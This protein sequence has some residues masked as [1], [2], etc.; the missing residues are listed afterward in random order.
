MTIPKTVLGHVYPAKVLKCYEHW[1]QERM[2]F[3]QFFLRVTSEEWEITD[4]PPIATTY[5]LF[6][7]NAS[8][9]YICIY[10]YILL[11]LPET[12]S[13]KRT[14]I[15]WKKP[16]PQRKTSFLHSPVSLLSWIISSMAWEILT[17]RS[18]FLLVRIIQGSW[19]ITNPNNALSSGEIPQRLP[20]QMLQGEGYSSILQMI[21]TVQ[22]C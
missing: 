9:L 12:P 6:H 17:E 3:N 5:Q 2:F 18:Q 13:Q 22:A 10:M 11:T 21:Q 20:V 8:Q 16:G 14:N 4:N 15:C 7:P 19:Y 1:Y